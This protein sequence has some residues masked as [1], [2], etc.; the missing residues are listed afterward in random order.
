MPSIGSLIVGGSFDS[1]IRGL[2]EWPADE[3]PPVAI[4]FWSFRVM[5]G[6]GMLMMFVG[7]FGAFLMWRGTL[8]DQRWFLRTCMLAGPSGFVAVI[9]GWIV[10][11]VGRQPYT[12][13]GLLRTVDSVS[14][15]TAAAVETSLIVFVFVYTI[16]FGA[17]LYYILQ[18]I[19]R[20]PEGPAQPPS[21]APD[22]PVLGT[23][24]ALGRDEAN[25]FGGAR[26]S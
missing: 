8:R 16:I 2:K 20:G 24:L 17:G 10:A 22:E 6:L 9:S 12:V 18:L 4:V 21:A 3:R 5:V 11:E 1:K 13:Y 19:R 7:L 25:V 26:Q 14:P 15:V 23:P